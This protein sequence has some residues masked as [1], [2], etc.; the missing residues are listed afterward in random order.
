MGVLSD[1]LE[2]MKQQNMQQ[3]ALIVEQKKLNNRLV[4]VM[5]L[6][7]LAMVFALFN[8]CRDE[9]VTQRLERNQQ[10]LVILEGHLDDA[11]HLTQQLQKG[12]LQQEASLR[13]VKAEVRQTPRIV[14]NAVT[15][16]LQLEV[17]VAASSRNQGAHAAP[18]QKPRGGL[19]RA[20]PDKVVPVKMGV[21]AIIPLKRP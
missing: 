21:T 16:Q 6:V 11:L 14:A 7:T 17:P 18:A 5:V 1:I 2:H 3:R 15:G 19:A 4:Y 10:A 13:G 8:S 12:Q 20:R 9:G